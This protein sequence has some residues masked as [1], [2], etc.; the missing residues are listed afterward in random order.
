MPQ[1]PNNAPTYNH[2]VITQLFK[3][4]LHPIKKYCWQYNTRVLN[5]HTHNC[6]HKN[7]AP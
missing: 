2:F 7:N 4:Y 3:V 6:G 1:T 5:Q